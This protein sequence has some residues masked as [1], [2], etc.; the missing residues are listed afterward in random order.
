MT[1]SGWCN[2]CCVSDGVLF[3]QIQRTPLV[4]CDYVRTKQRVTDTSER[5]QLSTLNTHTDTHTLTQTYPT[6]VADVRVSGLIVVS[7]RDTKIAWLNITRHCIDRLN[8]TLNVKTLTRSKTLMTLCRESAYQQQQQQCRQRRSIVSYVAPRIAS[9]LND[10]DWAILVPAAWPTSQPAH[11]HCVD[12]GQ[13]LMRRGDTPF[14]FAA[15][16]TQL[17]AADAVQAA[18]TS[19]LL[20]TSSSSSSL[21]LFLVVAVWPCQTPPNLPGDRHVLRYHALSGTPR[22]S[23]YVLISFCTQYT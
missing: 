21:S 20:L 14:I 19:L 22:C 9:L 10:V 8:Q 7:R 1:T 16:L 2:N 5:V 17:P 12:V 6:C 13:S 23:V 11:H 3:E 18:A 4:W 15:S